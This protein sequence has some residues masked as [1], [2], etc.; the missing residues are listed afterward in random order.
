MPTAIFYK[1]S[2]TKSGSLRGRRVSVSGDVSGNARSYLDE[3]GKTRLSGGDW[4][5]PNEDFGE[6]HMADP[7]SRAESKDKKKDGELKAE[8][9]F[10]SHKDYPR[11]KLFLGGFLKKRMRKERGT[12]DSP[13]KEPKRRGWITRVGDIWSY[14]MSKRLK[15]KK[16]S[17]NT[18]V[19]HNFSVSLAPE[20]VSN[21]Y[22]SGVPAHPFL[23]RVVRDTWDQYLKE[24]GWSGDEV[25]Y[26][27]GFHLD[28][29]N[30]HIQMMVFPWTEFG[31]RLRLSNRAKGPDGKIHNHLTRLSEIA[32]EKADSMATRVLDPKRDPTLD[33]SLSR[34]ILHSEASVQEMTKQSSGAMVRLTHRLWSAYKMHAGSVSLDTE[35]KF[36]HMLAKSCYL[37]SEVGEIDNG[38]L[39]VAIS[40]KKGNPSPYRSS[41]RYW[42][43]LDWVESWSSQE[44]RQERVA[45]AYKRFWRDSLGKGSKKQESSS[46][47]QRERANLVNA[48]LKNPFEIPMG[49]FEA[50][51]EDSR[52][53]RDFL[54]RLLLLGQDIIYDSRILQEFSSGVS[55]DKFKVPFLQRGCLSAPDVNFIQKPFMGD[56]SDPIMDLAEKLRGGSLE[57]M[58]AGIEKG[59]EI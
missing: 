33:Y 30:I 6:G 44:K 51:D 14:F 16:P 3:T 31:N 45:A 13:I 43:A 29:K 56:V 38:A 35:K 53:I 55:E 47:S 42:L 1:T 15:G 52:K 28:T 26:L 34:R 19:R 8:S 40:E 36:K 37:D 18:P 2:S 20:L 9:K 59:P 27:Y 49:F 4:F 25:G 46:K 21:L 23:D 50:G 39:D 10:I 11:G 32:T 5:R 48:E 41:S 58:G 54:E 7:I 24:Q 12:A 17:K 22:A 57:E